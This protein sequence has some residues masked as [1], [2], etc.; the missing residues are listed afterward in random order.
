MSGGVRLQKVC[1]PSKD[2]PLEVEARAA[3]RSACC[4]LHGPG[5]SAPLCVSVGTRGEGL[6]EV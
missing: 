5:L 6:V 2:C 3:T 1:L 4:W